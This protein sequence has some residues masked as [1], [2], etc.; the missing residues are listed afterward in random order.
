[1]TAATPRPTRP[2][3]PWTVR[4]AMW[5]A[6]HR[7]P[8]FALWFVLTIGMFVAS[9]AAGGTRTAEAVASNGQDETT[10]ESQQ[11]YDVFNASGSAGDTTHQTLLIVGTT[12][13]TI[14]DPGTKAALDDI[15]AKLTAHTATVDGATASTFAGIVDPRQAPA[16]LGLI[17]PDRTAV[18]IPV[19]VPGENDTVRQRLQAVPVLM[20][21]LR[22][23]HPALRIHALDG[24][25]ANDDIRELVNSG[26][27]ASLRLTIPLT[28]LRQ[29]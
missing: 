12:A 6:R 5:S 27:D 22:A 26:L 10:F 1:M 20:D 7:W 19:R 17:A 9:I 24:I 21:E 8:V 16:E 11:A 14:D 4:V 18:R 15:L 25:L 2:R 28:F 3:G 23:A 13:G 29:A